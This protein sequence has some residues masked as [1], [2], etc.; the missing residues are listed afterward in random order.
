M[1]NIYSQTNLSNKEKLNLPLLNL[2]QLKV[3]KQTCKTEP[4]NQNKNL[5]IKIEENDDEIN[6]K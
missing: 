3:E 5:Y 4:A 2:K 1:K 6:D